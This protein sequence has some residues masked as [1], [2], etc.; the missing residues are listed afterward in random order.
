[1]T[2]LLEAVDVS[3]G[4]GELEIVHGVSVN[5][6]AGE[7]VTIIGPNGA[8]K[9]TLLKAIAGVLPKF[10]GRVTFDGADVTP[11]SAPKMVA[12]GA[13]FVPPRAGVVESVD[14]GEWPVALLN[15]D[16]TT[17][18][19]GVELDAPSMDFG[20]RAAG[21]GIVSMLIL[22]ALAFLVAEWV[23]YRKGLMP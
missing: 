3:T 12:V 23:L 14:G 11:L 1:M 13:S 20:A 15:A 10:A 22:A 2:A 16:I 17:D 6:E 19:P 5:V 7:I 8:G 4:Y 9:S 21:I 18:A